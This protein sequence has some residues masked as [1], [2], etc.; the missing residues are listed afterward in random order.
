[1]EKSE[2]IRELKKEH[3]DLSAQLWE[4]SQRLDARSTGRI[5]SKMEPIEW[6]LH[7][8]ENS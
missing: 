8:L 2:K 6:E 4:A 3:K 1:M 7:R 5:L